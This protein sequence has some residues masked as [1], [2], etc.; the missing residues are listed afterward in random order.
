MNI[1]LIDPITDPLWA[2]L[3]DICPSSLFHSPRWIQSVINTYGFTV[4]A[5]VLC[6]DN[7]EPAAGLTFCVIEDIAGKRIAVMPFSDYADPIVSTQ[8]EWQQLIGKLLEHNC[9][10]TVRPLHNDIP[11]SDERFA[12][13]NQA[14]WH[15]FSLLP[16]LDTL[17]GNMESGARRAVKKAQEHGVTIR[18]AEDKQMLRA[19]FE[20]H[21]GV[22]KQK[23]GMLAQPYSFFENIWDQFMAHDQGFLMVATLDDKVIGA[24]LFLIW[25]DTVYYK[26]NASD[27]SAATYRMNDL[28]IWEAIKYAKQRGLARWD[29]GLSDWDQEGLL[30]FKRKYATEEKTISFLR[31]TPE[32]YT[33]PQGSEFRSM[34]NKIV[35]MVTDKDVPDAITE[36]AGDTLYRFFS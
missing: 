5:L 28:L 33:N 3:L 23:Y 13:F 35:E 1:Q 18:I 24:T 26:F 7:R 8:D 6:D 2:R 32:G 12:L 21:Q 30:R 10:V 20:L 29:F 4:R 19:F 22:R 15:G 34:L 31:Y 25:Q 36:R 11:L 17:W 16:E 14:K 27:A 9:P